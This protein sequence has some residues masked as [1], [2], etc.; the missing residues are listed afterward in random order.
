MLVTGKEILED[1]HKNN[2]A[3]GAFNVNNM[4]IVQAI[5]EAAEETNSPVILQASQGGLKYAGIE[6]IAALGK[7][8]ARN[9]KVPVALHLDHGTDFDQ[10]M[11]C[12]RHGFT[13]VMIDG[14][15][16]E[17]EENVAI[18]KKVVEVAH[19]VGVS[20]EAELGKIGGTED[21]V[22]VDEREATFTDPEEAKKFV[23][24]TNVDSLAI[25]VGTAHG[26][27]KGEPKLDFDRIKEI[28]EITNIPLVLHGSSGVPDESIKKAVSLGINKINIDTD[29]RVAFTNA[30][31]DFL[32]KNPDNIDPRKILG[33]AREAMKEAVVEKMKLFGSA[34]R[35]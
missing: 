33:P 7:V 20:V 6:Y 15:R 25:A 5:I 17:F 13:S 31:K 22:T 34:G 8:A 26:L 11:L 29:L 19:A 9:A 18:T 2:Y 27:Y 28:K 10:V 35:A 4:E 16:F 24:E 32:E 23:E 3:V 14:S 21:N 30:I 1:A 12:I